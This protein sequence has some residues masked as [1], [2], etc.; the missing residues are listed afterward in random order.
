M[1]AEQLSIGK[2]LA[3]N[4]ARRIG[5]EVLDSHARAQQSGQH[6][7]RHVVDGTR[8]CDCLLEVVSPALD[9]QA[10]AGDT[11]LCVTRNGL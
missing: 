11:R 6:M 5:V 7:E 4:S 2:A 1:I 10:K 8:G 9:T 3:H